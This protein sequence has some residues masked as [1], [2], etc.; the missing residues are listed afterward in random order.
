M[1]RRELSSLTRTS[2]LIRGY[3][4]PLLYRDLEISLI[5]CSDP[6][7]NLLFR[8]ISENQ[9]LANL[10]KSITIDLNPRLERDLPFFPEIEPLAALSHLNNVKEINVKE[11]KGNYI[12][13]KYTKLLERTY[14]TKE[15]SEMVEKAQGLVR[16][17][18]QKS[19]K[20]MRL[21]GEKTGVE[22]LLQK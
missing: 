14:K 11:I 22:K 3:V 21:I 8:T 13:K 18:K 2:K 17:I 6:N 20:K 16:K 9:K 7:Y 1:D 10:V 19:L 12:V 15:I 5:R 4:L